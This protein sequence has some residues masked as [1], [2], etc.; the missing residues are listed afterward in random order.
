MA[1]VEAEAEAEGGDPRIPAVCLP[2][3]LTLLALNLVSG[4]EV[5]REDCQEH[6]APCIGLRLYTGLKVTLCTKVK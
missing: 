1:V 2:R 6:L 3:Q 4:Y 5:S